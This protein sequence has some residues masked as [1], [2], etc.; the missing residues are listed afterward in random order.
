MIPIMHLLSMTLMIYSTWALY[1]LKKSTT[2][3]LK[4]MPKSKPEKMAKIVLMDYT[5]EINISQRED[6]AMKSGWTVSTVVPK[7]AE[8]VK[9]VSKP[10]TKNVPKAKKAKTTQTPS[11][12]PD[13]YSPQKSW[14]LIW[15]NGNVSIWSFLASRFKSSRIR[16]TDANSSSRPRRPSS[17][18]VNATFSAPLPQ[19]PVKLSLSACPPQSHH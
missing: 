18:K 1:P 12:N 9:P 6:S 10:V 11:V 2:L 15:K 13:N 19:V 16:S 5:G 17:F 8:S 3:I 7:V 4:S 14:T